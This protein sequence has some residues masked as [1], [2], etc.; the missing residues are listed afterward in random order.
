[1]TGAKLIIDW[2]NTG[3][4]I[5]GLKLGQKHPVVRLAGLFVAV[6]GTYDVHSLERTFGAHAHAHL[7]VTDKMR[8]VLAKT[9]RMCVAPVDQLIAQWHP[10][11]DAHAARPTACDLPPTQRRGAPQGAPTAE[12]D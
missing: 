10:R 6:S 1:M 12:L 2:H 11:P 8:E 4:S 7:F 9:W 3:A 5:L